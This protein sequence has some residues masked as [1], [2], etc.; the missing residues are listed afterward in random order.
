MFVKEN[1]DKKNKKIKNAGFCKPVL[2]KLM[3]THEYCVKY[4]FVVPFICRSSFGAICFTKEDF[5][6]TELLDLALV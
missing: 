5:F 2:D 1:L 6:K 3:T 4:N